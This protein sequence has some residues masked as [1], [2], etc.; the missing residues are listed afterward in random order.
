MVVDIFPAVGLS[1]RVRGS[2]RAAP[3]PHG[4]LG[5]IPACAGE[6]ALIRASTCAIRVYPRVCG[7][8][9][10][11]AQSGVL[12]EGLSPRVRG[13]RVMVVAPIRGRG[14][15]PACAGEPDNPN[16]RQA[17]ARVYP[18][19][20][21]GALLGEFC[22]TLSQGLSPRVR[23]SPGWTDRTDRFRGSIPA[24][25]G[26]PCTSPST[27]TWPGV[28]PRVCGGASSTSTCM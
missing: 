14:S 4:L 3:K 2:R 23:G 21:G 28:Y 25:A 18:R 13:S 7:G 15:I 16:A 12:P 22:L 27:A 19:V 1:P 5:S 6:P 17:D 8:A 11:C 9:M 20:C 10:F 24:C 26:E